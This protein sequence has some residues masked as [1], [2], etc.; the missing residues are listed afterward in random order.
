MQRG[1]PYRIVFLIA[2]L[3]LIGVFLHYTRPVLAPIVFAGLLAMVLLPL[4]TKLEKK[5]VPKGLAVTICILLLVV[6]LGIIVSILAWQV[7]DMTQHA[8]SIEKN[9][10]E[11]IQQI[12]TYAAK[13]LGIPPEKQQEILKKQQQNSSNRITTTVMTAMTSAGTI[14]GTVLLELVYIF[15][16]LYFRNHLKDFLLRLGPSSKHRN[17]LKVLGDVKQVSQDYLTGLALMILSL[18]IMYSI[19]FSV[20]G[21]K[22]AFFFAILCGLL[23]IVPFVGNI[24]GTAL[25]VFA[26]L[27]GGGDMKLVIGI[28]VTY[29]IVQ[30][31]QSYFL[32]PLVVGRKVNIHPMITIIGIV[33]S[34]F[35]WGIPGMILAIPVIAVIKIL[36]DHVDQLKPVGYLLGDENNGGPGP[37]QKLKK[38]VKSK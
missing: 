17:M 24:T 19:G 33:V 23:E 21:V 30:F 22:N 13:T 9:V 4:S 7:N 29:G 11:K 5:G 31:I 15:L 12:R 6:V 28:L 16:F 10:S 20:V 8:E 2:S 26:S 35:V 36:C 25:T 32:E 1:I 27:A 14:L 37:F 18:W 34:E 3:L 38:W